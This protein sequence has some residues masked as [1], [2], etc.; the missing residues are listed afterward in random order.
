MN[1]NLIVDPIDVIYLLIRTY[2][3][4]ILSAKIVL[5]WLNAQLLLILLNLIT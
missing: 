2:I 5:Q 3:K 4:L 1:Q